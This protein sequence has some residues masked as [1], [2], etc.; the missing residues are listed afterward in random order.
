MKITKAELVQKLNKIKGIV[1]KTTTMPVLQSILVKDGYL[2]ANNM[3]TTVKAKLEGAEGESFLL[4]QKAFDLISN[5]PA[6]EIEITPK[7]KDNIV[8]KTGSIKNTY[9]TLDP[10]LF[11]ES[12]VTYEGEGEFELESEDLLNAMRHVAWA[13]ANEKKSSMMS[14]L[15]LQAHAGRLNFVALDGHVIAWDTLDYPGEFELLIP[16][17]TVDKILSVGLEGKVSIRHS[18]TGAVFATD[19][20]EV[21]TRLVDGEFYKYDKLFGA[22]PISTAINRTE[23]LDAMVRAKLCTAEQTPSRFEFSGI[24]LDISL[25]DNSTDYNETLAIE[26]ELSESFV[27]GFDARLVIEALKAFESRTVNL[28]MTNGKSPMLI[29]ADGSSLK[30]LVLPVNLRG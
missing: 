14:A 28:G 16:K 19:M 23:L 17:N 30:T 20:F 3:E 18:K 27:I 22:A 24:S 29:E 10:E 6:G 11:P 7:G 13:V 26:K 12:E 2:I 15:C 8:I 21:Y 5:L 4:P 25:R 1:P 9:K